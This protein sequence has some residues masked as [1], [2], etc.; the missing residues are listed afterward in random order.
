MIYK[1]ILSIIVLLNED[2]NRNYQQL[3]DYWKEE[4]KN[5]QMIMDENID[6]HQR[7]DKYQQDIKDCHDEIQSIYDYYNDYIEVYR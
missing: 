3:S 5:S 4:T 7:I 2:M 6:L 1:R